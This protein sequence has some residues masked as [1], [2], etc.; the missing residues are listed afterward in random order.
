MEG[1]IPQVRIYTSYRCSPCRLFHRDRCHS[2]GGDGRLFSRKVENGGEGFS[3]PRDGKS[4][5]RRYSPPYPLYLG[6]EKINFQ[7][8]KADMER[9]L[10]PIIQPS[11][12]STGS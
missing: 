4:Q 6:Y 9:R 8:L 2:A 10:L 12:S 1:T 7:N 5:V 3:R 11:F